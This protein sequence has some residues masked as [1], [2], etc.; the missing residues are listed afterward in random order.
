MDAKT[1]YHEYKT[2]FGVVYPKHE[3]MFR[4]YKN[5]QR[6]IIYSLKASN[7]SV[8]WYITIMFI[9]LK[10]RKSGTTALGYRDQF[11][12]EQ[13]KGILEFQC[14]YKKNNV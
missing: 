7:S 5:I 11:A 13:L 1:T 3:Y 6:M 10:M 9:I 8:C 4:F 12:R 2:I 14:S